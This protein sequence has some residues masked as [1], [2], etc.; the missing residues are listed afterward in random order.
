MLFMNSTSHTKKIGGLFVFIVCAL[1]MSFLLINVSLAQA[2]TPDKYTLLEALPCIESPETVDGNGNKIPAVTCSESQIREIDFQG[3]PSVY[4]ALYSDN[5]LVYKGR[6]QM[7]S[8]E[9]LK[10]IFFSSFLVYGYTKNAATEETPYTAETTYYGESKRK[11]EEIVEEYKKK[12][13]NTVIVQPSI[14]HGPGLDFGF[15]SLFPAVQKGRFLFIGSGNNLEQLGYIDNLIDG[16]ILAAKKNNA[17]GHD[18]IA[19]F[20]KKIDPA[21]KIQLPLSSHL[22]KQK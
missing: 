4:Y 15:A 18:N 20:A 17:I 8:P 14:I 3:Y 12:G 21:K 5:P 6:Q 10:F 13:M 22:T 2:Q 7:P 9:Q 1:F 16:V 19:R 11:G